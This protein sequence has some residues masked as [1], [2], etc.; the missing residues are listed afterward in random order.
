MTIIDGKSIAQAIKG[1]IA[2]TVREWLDKGRPAPHLAAVIVGEEGAAKTYVASIERSCKEVGF[3]ASVYQFPANLK[4]DDLLEVVDFLSNDDETDGIIIQLPLPK[5]IDAE[6]VINHLNPQKDVDCMHPSNLGKIMSGDA[7]FIPATPYGALE[8][9]RRSGITTEGKNCVVVGRSNIVGKPLAMLLSSRAEMGNATVT[10]C[11]TK[12]QNLP[13]ICAGAD[14]LLVAVGQPEMVTADFVKAGATVID[15][16][17]HRIPDETAEKGYRLCGDVKFDEVAK[18][19][20]FITP[21][22]GGVGQVTMACLLLNTL[23]A[24]KRQQGE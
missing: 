19:C 3:M 16:G 10:I 13:Q 20:E 18:K 12:T 15:I 23:K 5:H 14:I 21:V 1:E 22:P 17:V 8:L 9:L 2:T 24:S 11:H 4:E 7:L 6:K